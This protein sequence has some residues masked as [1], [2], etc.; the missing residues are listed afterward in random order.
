MCHAPTE[1]VDGWFWLRLDDGSCTHLA[2]PLI[3]FFPEST[4]PSYVVNIPNISGSLQVI[5]T[6]RSDDQELINTVA[7][8]DELCD[9]LSDITEDGDAPVHGKLD[10]LHKTYVLAR[11]PFD[12]LRR[13]AATKLYSWSHW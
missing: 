2:N 13:V 4:Q 11:C 6:E 7:L 8:D 5:D 1:K 9:T 10:L 12:C 3:Q